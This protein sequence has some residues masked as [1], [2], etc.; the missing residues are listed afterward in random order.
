MKMKTRT[1]RIMMVDLRTATR[2]VAGISDPL[3]TGGRDRRN[4]DYEDQRPNVKTYRYLLSRLQQN[5]LIR[6]T[7]RHCYWPG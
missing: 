3:E 5:S 4:K 7:W 6:L 2:T 1:T